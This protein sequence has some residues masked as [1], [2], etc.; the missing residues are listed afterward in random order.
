MAEKGAR[1]L[2]CKTKP[3]L[4]HTKVFFIF[5]LPESTRETIPEHTHVIR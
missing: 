3:R 2:Q 5:F 1:S 4:S